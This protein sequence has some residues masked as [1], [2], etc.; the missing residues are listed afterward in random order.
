[1]RW[2]TSTEGWGRSRWQGGNARSNSP[3]RPLRSVGVPSLLCDIMSVV[4][5]SWTHCV[6]FGCVRG[7]KGDED[8]DDDGPGRLDSSKRQR[9]GAL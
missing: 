2:R 3:V 5:H 8:D 4:F 6:G 9:G 1:M 7:V